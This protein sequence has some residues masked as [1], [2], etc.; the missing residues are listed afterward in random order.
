MQPATKKAITSGLENRLG[1]I[2]LPAAIKSKKAVIN[3]QNKD[4]RCFE[5]AILSALHH[6][7]V[8]Q[9]RTN[10]PSQ[11]KAYLGKLNFTGIESPVSLKDIDKFEKQ[12]PEIKGNVFG[13]E[14]DVYISRIN[15]TD[16][17]NANDLLLITNE[18]NQRYCWIKKFSML[19]SS[20]V[21]KHEHK[22]YFCKRC[23]PRQKG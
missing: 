15:K 23:F 18:E 17:Q 19:A 14:K 16:P 5:Y 7:E 20:Q 12:N 13:Y 6:N 10:R 21:S 9:K 3:V 22:Q 8:D 1:Y 11:Y 2:D 4:N